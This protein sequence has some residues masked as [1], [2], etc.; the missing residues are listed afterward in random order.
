A[1]PASSQEPRH[2]PP[3]LLAEGQFIVNS[4]QAALR[5]ASMVEELGGILDEMYRE[6]GIYQY[7]YYL[8]GLNTSGPAPEPF[9]DLI[10]SAIA[11][12][13]G[14]QQ[15][16]A[17]PNA[18][19][20]LAWAYNESRGLDPFVMYQIL[21]T[22]EQEYVRFGETVSRVYEVRNITV[23][24]PAF[25]M[26][27]GNVV[28]PSLA[29]HLD[30][31]TIASVSLDASTA[32]A[33]GDLESFQRAS[34]AARVLYAVLLAVQDILEAH[35]NSSKVVGMWP[36]TAVFV[37][38]PIGGLPRADE[39]SLMPAL[40][41]TSQGGWRPAQGGLLDYLSSRSYTSYII[42]R[43][44]LKPS[45]VYA[46]ATIYMKYTVPLNTTMKLLEAAANLTGY[47]AS[48]QPLDRGLNELLA[49]PSPLLGQ[50]PGGPAA[51]PFG[52]GNA[53]NLT[54]PQEGGAG[55]RVAADLNKILG[56]LAPSPSSLASG[57]LEQGLTAEAGR[58]LG[59][60]VDLTR[61]ALGVPRPSL[62]ARPPSP[63]ASSLRLG[64]HL[65][66][67]RWLPWAAALAGVAAALYLSAGRL[68]LL[69]GRLRLAARMLYA[70][71]A[72]RLARARAARRASGPVECY[73]AALA[74]VRPYA[75]P[76][77]ASETPREYLERALGAGLP[78]A[79][80]GALEAATRLYEEY[81]Y[82]GRRGGGGGCPLVP[83]SGGGA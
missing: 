26:P 1:A 39:E 11:P 21:F 31:I 65:A 77:G 59:L 66:L 43:H 40:A 57:L 3:D 62:N 5:I 54:A 81:R 23:G 49:A 56:E 4:T 22:L 19:R 17:Q 60:S 29:V 79:L 27:E 83:G 35:L 80:R 36:G 74:A 67:P 15:Q 78:G 58:G 16:G 44:I 46:N 42:S 12:L 64:L 45:T 76:K 73:I 30:Y 25:V 52:A 68:G 6:S 7:L 55:P 70:S 10:I 8:V 33:R 2:P 20:L 51:P 61:A 53:S 37:L 82:A 41:I 32:L 75:G 47:I 48:L 18:S 72:S 63:L 24:Y 69:G 13:P 38:E 28:P 14:A 9:P 34:S 50:L 71:L